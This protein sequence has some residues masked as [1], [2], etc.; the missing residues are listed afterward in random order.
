MSFTAPLAVLTSSDTLK[1]ITS[2]AISVDWNA[3][4]QDQ[5][6]MGAA[7]PIG[8]ATQTAAGNVA[9]ATTTTLVS[10]PASGSVRNVS[11]LSLTNRGAGV[12]TVRVVKDN[13]T[14]YDLF[15]EATLN[16]GESLQ[17]GS[18]TWIKYNAAGD[19]VVV[20]KSAP[21]GGYSG[22]SIALLKIGT[23][24]EAA[25]QFY[26]TSKDNG[27]PGAWAPGTPGVAGRATDGTTAADNGCIPWQNASLGSVYATQ[28]SMGST[29]AH[30]HFLFDCLWVN[31]AIAVTTTTSQTINSVAFPARDLNG[32]V[33]GEGVMVGILV[34]TATTNAGAVTNTTLSYT[35]SDGTPGRT[36]TIASFPITAVAGTI[37]WFQLQAGDRG[38]QSIQSITLGTS[39][40]G[41]AI[42][43][44][45]ARWIVNVPGVAA[46]IGASAFGMGQEPGV[47]LFDGTCLLHCYL[48]SAT[49]ATTSAG[50]VVLMEK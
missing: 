15:P 21:A 45:A 22:R 49:T 6:A 37:M 16:A 4:S 7:Y 8:P 1:L 42:S 2:A 35:N 12:Q 48:A 46:N 39:Y 23:A 41:G 13:G 14:A 43:L 3:A 31:T 34:T 33:N 27:F 47:E 28:F 20:T 40:G 50:V 5:P 11:Q 44:I 18:G 36:A 38:V 17:F 9:T 29:V 25:G 30:M 10:P 32:T 19:P 24:A 26:C